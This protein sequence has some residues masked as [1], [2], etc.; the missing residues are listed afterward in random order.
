MAPFRARSRI[1]E[2][3]A[4]GYFIV[5]TPILIRRVDQL[6]GNTL[7]PTSGHRWRGRP[8]SRAGVAAARSLIAARRRRSTRTLDFVAVARDLGLGLLWVA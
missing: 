1:M 4:L 5:L 3:N 2:S 6:F 8:K 7:S